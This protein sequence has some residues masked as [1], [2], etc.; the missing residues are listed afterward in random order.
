[1]SSSP[2]VRATI[3]SCLLS[4]ASNVLAQ[5]ISAYR[6]EVIQPPYEHRSDNQLT[7][8]QSPY[9]IN[10]TPVLQFVIFTVLNCPPNFLWQQFLESLFPSRTLHPTE[11]ALA[12]AASNDEK[13][14]DSEESTHTIV[15]PRLNL[16]NTIL[17]FLIDQT[18]GGAGNTIGFITIMAGLRGASMEEAIS[19]VREEF[20]PLLFAGAKLW[21]IVS[22]INFSLLETVEAR[23]LLGSLAGMAWGVYLSLVAANP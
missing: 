9:N 21:P 7:I 10:W 3:Q 4:A 16:R 5:T 17:K 18:V 12:A 8:T 11:A 23:N 19:L 22:I 13:E 6:T 1:M 20:W 14:L 2:I 15:E